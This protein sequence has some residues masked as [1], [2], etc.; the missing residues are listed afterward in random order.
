MVQGTSSS[1][2][3]SVLVTAL[4]RIFKQ[5]GFRVA[6]FKAQNMALNSFATREGGEIG[7]AQAVQAE[8]AGIEPSVDMNPVLLKP[9]GEGSSQLIVQGKVVGKSSA[10]SYYR[11]S[12]KLLKAV[13]ESL[14]RL[15]SS[16]E[17]V[18]IEGAGSP[19]E[20]NLK[21]R[22]IVNMRVAQM[23]K[24]PVILVGDIDRGGV[25][26]S[27]IGTLEL[28][29][30]EE[31]KYIKGFVINKFRGDLELLRPGLEF[32]ERRTSK[33]VLGVIPY[34]RGILIAQ[35]DS[36]YLEERRNG[37]PR[38]DLDIAVIH[39]PHISNY[40]DFDP[41]EE[42]SSV[43]YISHPSEL[44]S[45]HLIILPGTKN[46]LSDLRWLWRAGLA[47]EIIRRA[48]EGIPVIGICGGYQMLGKSVHD[49]EG[50]ESAG[51][52]LLGLGLLNRKTLFTP[53]KLVN[54]VRARVI[55]NEGLLEGMEGL[56]LTGYEIHMGQSEGDGCWAFHIF[57]TPQGDEDRFD[58]ALDERG[59][60]LGTYIH[61]LFHNF[62]LRQKLLNSLRRRYGL[63]EKS[64]ALDKERHYDKYD[65]LANL[66]R[67]NLD[68][69]AV[70]RIMEEGVG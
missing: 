38:A 31:R 46:T 18:V 6:P 19:A 32:L 59:L 65:K 42:E 68:L 47:E 9:E 56:E 64:P 55:S 24:S 52:S 8:A 22:E 49:P 45:P 20:I 67:S 36:V 15:L 25:F 37:V 28:L 34:F 69:K 63:P 5:D 39:L 26:A 66:V 53:S 23:A 17:I 29:E 14:E 70:Y 13:R 57:E 51:E 33:P 35:E 7:R 4:C 48:R 62:N 3:K 40:D 50:V 54:Q 1:V 60:I 43:R 12:G 10:S 61:G 44:G 11:D 16:F 21:E 41:L 27:L 2:G 30:E 58:G